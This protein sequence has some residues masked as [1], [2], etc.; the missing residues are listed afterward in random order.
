MKGNWVRDFP[1]SDFFNNEIAF[2]ELVQSDAPSQYSDTSFGKMVKY[3]E[4]DAFSSGK[5][6][7]PKGRA[8]KSTNSRDNYIVRRFFIF[9]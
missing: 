5:F 6:T 9:F 1:S 2:P 8:K 3:F 4:T 7:I